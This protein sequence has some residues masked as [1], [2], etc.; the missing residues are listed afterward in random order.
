MKMQ[1]RYALDK[2]NSIVDVFTL[3]R[4]TLNFGSVF[5]C[6]GCCG[7]VVAKLGNIKVKHFAHKSLTDNCNGE[8]YLHQL[9][10]KVFYAEYKK[11]LENSQPFYLTWDEPIICD[12]FEKNYRFTCDCTE[13]K[14][15]DL[16]RY[17][18]LISVEKSYHGFVADVL[19]HSSK[20][21]K[22]IF[23][24]FVVSHKCEENKLNSGIRI[25][26]HLVKEEVDL[27]ILK[28]HNLRANQ[29]NL[30]FYNFN[31]KT[32]KEKKPFCGGNCLTKNEA[33]VFVVHKSQKSILL[34]LIPAEI[35]KK[36]R[37]KVLHFKIIE[38]SR[39]IDGGQL[40]KEL[41]RETYFSADVPIK[42]CFL[43]RYHGIDGFENAIF[44]RVEKQSVG[45]N[46]AVDCQAYRP[47]RNMNECLE[48]DKQ[49]AEYQAQ[50][51]IGYMVNFLLPKP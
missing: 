42:N 2:D 33:L 36:I 45:S 39:G 16:T 29:K 48:K 12:Y 50:K 3:E 51:G 44:C 25:I 11:C 26:E 28:N 47:L 40:Y 17:F 30:F 21:D 35:E 34:N 24:E 38:N 46:Q 7:E 9:S 37:N 15:Y 4:H 20:N 49:N 32:Q 10:K 5:K 1:Y 22:V 8:T 31:F 43:C 18:D 13:T 14:N 19:L 6:I 27:E 23:V 41:V